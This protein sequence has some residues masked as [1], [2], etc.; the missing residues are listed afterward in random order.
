MTE[1]GFVLHDSGLYGGS[2]DSLVGEDG[3]VE[4]KT[5]APHLFLEDLDRGGI[6]PEYQWQ[7]R[8][9]CLVLGRS[10]CDLAQYCAPLGRLRVE[11]LEP[12]EDE[13]ADLH[14]ALQTFCAELDSIESRI[15]DLLTDHA[16]PGLL[17]AAG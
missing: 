15:L 16:A 12:T 8:M 13:L 3:L 6:P 4:I 10:W 2:P 5:R 7:M 14:D 17:E 11:H 1:V 9:Q